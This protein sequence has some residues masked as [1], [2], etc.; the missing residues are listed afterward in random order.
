MDTDLA[1]EEIS[2]GATA[3]EAAEAAAADEAAKA[4]TA[5]KLAEDEAAKA[6]EEVGKAEEKENAK[7]PARE[8]GEGSDGHTD[9]TEAAGAPGATPAT[10]P[11]A[12]AATSTSDEPQPSR[13]LKAGDGVY[14]NL[15]WAAGSRAPTEGEVF[16]EDILAAAGL[17]LVDAPSTSGSTSEE[18]QLLQKLLSLY[19]ARREKLTSRE[20]L[21]ARAEADIQKHVEELQGFHRQALHSLATERA[22][23]A[24]ERKAFLLMKAEIEEQ[25]QEV[26]QKLSAQEGQLAQRKVDLDGHEEDL[27]GREAALAET[28]RQKDEEVS[29][30]VA[31]RTQGQEQKH[32]EEVEA[33]GRDYVGKLKQATD[34][35]AAAETARKELEAK[36]TKLEA[37]LEANG[38]ELSTLKSEKEKVLHDLSEMQ[39]TI[40]ERGKQLSA[41]NDSIE[42]K[43]LQ[44]EKNLLQSAV[45]AQNT[46]RDNVMLWTQSLVDTAA[47]ID[48]ELTKMG[49]RDFGYSTDENMQPSTKLSLFFG[50]V[51]EA[52]KQLQDN[53]PAQLADESRRLCQGALRKVLMKVAYRNP[54]LNLTNVLRSL[55]KD[56]DLEAL[57]G[58]V[59]PIVNK[60]SEIK[61]VE[62][63]RRD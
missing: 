21:V 16:D 36:V 39:V 9:G 8:A 41:A 17:K 63:E 2:A 49:V 11:S 34:A 47:N 61:R 29:R 18:E 7:A 14:I 59:A 1:A 23:L 12:T 57:E 38:K 20:A 26:A 55:P 10:E 22:Q 45:A 3:D 62:G 44:D 5:D 32:K 37:D 58:L 35:A 52:L 25:Q 4:A 51:V 24:E 31:E 48:K 53:Y 33:L 15:P 54:G 40:A 6:A 46:F 27:T 43:E 30:L 60:V 56:A 28:L 42:A 19:R 50:G 13:Y